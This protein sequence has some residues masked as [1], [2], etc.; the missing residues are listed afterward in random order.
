MI[1]IP[2]A[3][4]HT[5]IAGEG[6]AGR[7]WIAAL[8]DVVDELLQRWSCTP[9][10]PV[11][12]GQV[13]IVVPVRNPDLPPAVIKVSFPHP[14]NVHEPDAYEAWQ[15]RGATY[16][17]ARADEHFAMLLERATD[18]TLATI[19]NHEEALVIQGG[20]SR[21][22]A[23]EGPTGLPRLADQAKCWER[24]MRATAT[25]FG[26]PIPSRIL[27]AALATLRDLGP[28]Q[29]ATLVH[30]DLHDANVL[31]SDREPWLAVDPKGQV[32]DPAQDALNVIRSPRFASVLL[33]A[34]NLRPAVLRLLEIYCEAA[35][36]EFDRARRWMQ[37]GAVREALWGRAH[38]DPVWLVDCT[39]Q[40]AAVLTS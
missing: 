33:D 30:G 31:A 19:A 3:F 15:G 5:K 36:I 18:R 29:P 11:M 37:A 26:D 8:P 23:V 22:L 13:G 17:Y 35:G 24:E 12:H 16:L 10:G 4:A 32:G 20:L 38:G 1:E 21:R 9:A 6:E 39:E 7:A 40:L 27:D 34:P 2:E 25:E 28:D 14:G